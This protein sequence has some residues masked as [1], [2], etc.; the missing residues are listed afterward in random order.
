MLERVEQ[1][2]PVLTLR[3]A[4]VV[5]VQYGLAMRNQEVWALSL[6]DV[7]GRR[8]VV[9][10]VLSYGE[11]DAGKTEYATGPSRRPPIDELL[12][13][14]LAAWSAALAAH[15]HPTAAD[16][17]LFRGDLAGHGAPDGHMTRTQ[18]SAWGCQVLR[19]SRPEGRRAVAATSMATSSVPRPTRCG[20][21]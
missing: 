14:D 10:E 18:A 7:A 13:S 3:D 20:A 9:R 2:S 1:R 19:A 6:G 16:D 11:L 12:A 8:A 4:T 15:G 5:A 21:E 17:F